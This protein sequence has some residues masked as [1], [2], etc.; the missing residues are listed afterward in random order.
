MRSPFKHNSISS[1]AKNKATKIKKM[2]DIYIIFW[3]IFMPK[4]IESYSEIIEAN[5][6][7]VRVR[8]EFKVLPDERKVIN[9]LCSKSGKPLSVYLKDFILQ[10]VRGAQ[11]A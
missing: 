5:I 2:R 6:K 8:V 1:T 9:S 7:P 4:P 10:E 3:V 11:N